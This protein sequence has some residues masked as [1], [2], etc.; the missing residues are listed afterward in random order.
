MA[1]M[2][3]RFPI[4]SDE[5]TAKF[6]PFN[7]VVYPKIGT[8]PKGVG[9][10]K[11]R[12][13]SEAKAE[14]DNM[15]IAGFLDHESQ[16]KEKRMLRQLRTFM[17]LPHSFLGPKAGEELRKLNR[18]PKKAVAAAA[19]AADARPGAPKLSDQ[20]A[21]RLNEL[22]RL[23][24]GD[25]RPKPHMG[26]RAYVKEN[27]KLRKLL[28]L[29]RPRGY[30]ETLQAEGMD[31][32][33]QLERRHTS[34]ALT[35][36]KAWRH[37]LAQKFWGGY[38]FKVKAVVSIQRIA[39]GMVVRSLLPRWFARRIYIVTLLQGVARGY[40]FRKVWKG[41]RRW[42]HYNMSRIQA[43]AKGYIARRVVREKKVGIAALHIQALW[44]GAVG[45][46]R[47]DRLFLDNSV[48]VVQKCVR[49]RLGRKTYAERYETCQW[50][51]L[52]IQR[53]FRGSK[54]RTVRNRLMNDRE[55]GDRQQL[56]DVLAVEL[57]WWQ[58]EKERLERRFKGKRYPERLAKLRK[59]LKALQEEVTMHEENY[60]DLDKQ[61]NMLSPRAVEQTWAQA[62]DDNLDEHWGWLQDCK[63]R[64]IFKIGYKLVTLE[65]EEER[66]KKKIADA[67]Y[68]ASEVERWRTAELNDMFA[69]ASRLRWGSGHSLETRKRVA[70]QKRR[71][72]VRYFTKAG[73]PDKQRRPGRP[74]DPEVLAGPERDTF[75]F[76]DH[77]ILLGT[78]PG[79]REP[80][81]GTKA[82]LQHISNKLHHANMTSTMQ[83]ADSL[84]APLVQKMD[85]AHIAQH[86]VNIKDPPAP[87]SQ[88]WA[89]QQY[90]LEKKALMARG[91][92]QTREDIRLA[93]AE[94]EAKA[95]AEAEA[96]AFEKA[97]ADAGTAEGA[98]DR[99][100]AKHAK[101][102]AH[103][104]K[105]R[106]SAIPWQLLD[107][108]E[109]EKRQLEADIR[110]N[111]RFNKAP[112]TYRLKSDKKKKKSK[113]S[114]KGSKE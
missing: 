86:F 29:K 104:S 16:N 62:L 59:E 107:E 6:L 95:R 45:R 19:K 28:K 66:W 3:F 75:S 78:D 25:K 64:A 100:S 52:T 60:L 89:K 63:Q 27:R 17:D 50:A 61:R 96:A 9:K 74:W 108:L 33:Y 94:A 36:Q 41:Q 58:D 68:E 67:A 37:Y 7:D 57:E 51:A 105:M 48:S 82:S 106:T 22:G 87:V 34:A 83:Q 79:A 112:K 55:A 101:Q 98:A 56:L 47:A 54:G 90:A 65:E 73:K 40:I 32:L 43:A 85:G 11:A 10:E 26:R 72:A 92:R 69:R 114:K 77:D 4:T 110:N 93:A 103:R 70:D 81:I 31:A 35:I 2:F 111:T 71:W 8:P 15:W 13:P 5:E 84:L 20:D 30:N 88:K 76:L 53:F 24:L 42:E 102:R 113:K 109:K 99:H 12:A 14:A 46:A 91:V 44:R 1:D 39:K 80:M 97:K 18:K 49:G 38:M 21:A 23:V